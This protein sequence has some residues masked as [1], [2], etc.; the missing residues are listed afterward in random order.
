MDPTR[1]CRRVAAAG[2]VL[3]PLCFS[4]ADLLRRLIEPSSPTNTQ[5]V[6]AVHQHPTGWLVA[7]LLSAATAFLLAPGALAV[8]LLVRGRGARPTVIGSCLLAVGAIAA[9]GHAVGYFGSVGRYAGSGVDAA[10]VNAVESA[11][12]VLG[13]VLIVLFMIG[14]MIGSIVFAVGMRRAGAVPIWVPVAAVVFVGA[15]A[16]GGVA[17]GVVGLLAALATFLPAARSV[18]GAGLDRVAEPVPA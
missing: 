6:A 8:T 13:T 15:G 5:L 17:A 10:A 7:G 16:S 18:A 9:L 2:L 3:G 4:V 11:N 12:D 1:T 14:M